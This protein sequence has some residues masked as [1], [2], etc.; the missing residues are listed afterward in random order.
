MSSLFANAAF[1]EVKKKPTQ[2][3]PPPVI[4]ALS[5][6]E[7]AGTGTVFNVNNVKNTPI[8]VLFWDKNCAICQ[9]HIKNLK[10][11]TNSAS[12]AK[13]II[14]SISWGPKEAK[15][16]EPASKYGVQVLHVKTDYRKTLAN[17]GNVS[18]EMPFTVLTNK[19]GMI[20]ETEVGKLD[21]NGLKIA[22]QSCAN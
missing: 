19:S 16:L 1:A 18:G 9:G 17:L 14:A 3:P 20:C 8:L 22:V 10:S 21:P 5:Q 12:G 11:L 7:I 13:I 2:L 15:L 4:K 6:L